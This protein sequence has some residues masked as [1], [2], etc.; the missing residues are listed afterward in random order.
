MQNKK[1]CLSDFTGMLFIFTAAALIL[2]YF[3]EV[4]FSG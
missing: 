1:R 4:L 2:I 3:Y